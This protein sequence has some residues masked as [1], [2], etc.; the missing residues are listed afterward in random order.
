MK[1]EKNKVT[2]ESLGATQMIMGV[3][4]RKGAARMH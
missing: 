3:A 2:E 4:T 1:F